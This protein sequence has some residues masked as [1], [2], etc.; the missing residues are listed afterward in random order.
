MATKSIRRYSCVVIFA[1]TFLLIG[2]VP[3]SLAGD[4]SE[5]STG[6]TK[7]AEVTVEKKTRAGLLTKELRLVRITQHTQ[8]AD[9]AGKKVGFESLAAPCKAVVVYEPEPKGDHVA[10]SVTVREFLPGATSQL[11]QSPE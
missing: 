1:A 3:R 9:P 7:T 6:P 2:T 10:V 4:T 11:T 5:K 8:Y